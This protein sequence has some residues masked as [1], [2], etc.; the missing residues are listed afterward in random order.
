MVEGKIFSISSF[1]EITIGKVRQTHH[2]CVDVSQPRDML[3]QIYE[4]HIFLKKIIAEK[5]FTSLFRKVGGAA[6][7][8]GVSPYPPLDM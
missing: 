3:V 6:A 7:S 2:P 8:P 5:S 4:G 1:S